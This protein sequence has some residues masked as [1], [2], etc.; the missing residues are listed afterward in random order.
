M[1]V[2][3][4][5]ESPIEGTST[6]SLA[7]SENQRAAAPNGVAAARTG[8]A[9]D[10]AAA[11]EAVTT[12]ARSGM[13]CEARRAEIRAWQGGGTGDGLLREPQW[14]CREPPSASHDNMQTASGPTL[15]PPTE[16]VRGGRPGNAFNAGALHRQRGTR[17]RPRVGHH[18]K[19][20]AA[21]R[22]TA[23]VDLDS[24]TNGASGHRRLFSELACD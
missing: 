9:T 2:P 11:R 13:A 21:A 17:R 14:P 4:E 1:T 5:M 10:T 19:L 20:T 8:W 23:R 3:S 7:E 18:I 24:I 16:A 6:V 15:A 22:M 12:A